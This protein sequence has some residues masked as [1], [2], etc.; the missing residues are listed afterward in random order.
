ME[1]HREGIKVLIGQRN[2]WTKE[3]ESQLMG[4]GFHH[5]NTKWKMIR[6]AGNDKP[7]PY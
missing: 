5:S 3:A 1:Q 2:K 6:R 4:R 7:N